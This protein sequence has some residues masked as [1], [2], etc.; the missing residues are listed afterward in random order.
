MWAW[1]DVM[2]SDYKHDDESDRLEASGRLGRSFSTLLAPTLL[3]LFM[4][5]LIGICLM[6]QSTQGRGRG[7]RERVECVVC[8]CVYVL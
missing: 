2:P 5:D 8:V 4:S 1:E 3:S 6:A 7:G